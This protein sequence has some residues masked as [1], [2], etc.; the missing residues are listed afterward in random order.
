MLSTIIFYPCASF[1]QADFTEIVDQFV[2]PDKNGNTIAYFGKFDLYI[3]NGQRKINSYAFLVTEE[4][5]HEKKYHVTKSWIRFF[6]DNTEGKKGGGHI[7]IIK[8][9]NVIDIGTR[10]VYEVFPLVDKIV[11]VLNSGQVY[12][13]LTFKCN[14]N[15]L[16]KFSE[17]YTDNLPQIMFGEPAKDLPGNLGH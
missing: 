13:V 1:G 16:E 7:D 14:G 3:C 11:F 6:A 5:V 15:S 2:K 17:V 4:Q 10:S 12:D 8:P 9:L